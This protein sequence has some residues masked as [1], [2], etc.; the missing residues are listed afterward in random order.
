MFRQPEQSFHSPPLATLA[1]RPEVEKCFSKRLG[2]PVAII[3]PIVEHP[4]SDSVLI[5]AIPPYLVPMLPTPDHETAPERST[6]TIEGRSLEIDDS[7]PATQSSPKAPSNLR[8]PSFQMLGIA[9]P[10]PNDYP[11]DLDC[12]VLPVDVGPISAPNDPLR[13]ANAVQ[14][15]RNTPLNSFVP[16]LPGSPVSAEQHSPAQKAV[17]HYILTQTP[18]DDNGVMNWTTNPIKSIPSDQPNSQSGP[19]RL[20]ASDADATPTRLPAM[21]FTPPHS[22]FLSGSGP[23]INQALPSLRK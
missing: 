1:F 9:A 20:P 19:T 2:D 13:T 15:V 8:L 7:I 14:V 21:A 11:V 3:S 16:R 10:H 17:R 6:A 18:P 4:A 12:S 23:W 5:P 22:S